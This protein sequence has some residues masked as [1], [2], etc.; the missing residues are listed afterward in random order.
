MDFIFPSELMN[1][2]DKFQLRA[3]LREISVDLGNDI[4]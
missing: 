2:V 4:G 3:R 1:G